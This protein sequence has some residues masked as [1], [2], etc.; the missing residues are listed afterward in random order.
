MG[1]RSFDKTSETF[2]AA[3]LESPGS[4]TTAWSY[5]FA[6]PPAGSY[7]VHVRAG[8]AAGNAT[9]EASQASA[10]FTI[11]STAPP[12]PSITSGP[13]AETASK[14]ASFSFSDSQP[15]VTFLCAKDDHTFATCS[16]P[17]TYDTISQGEHTFYV[18]ARDAAGNV[19][20]PASYTWT[21]VKGFAIEG[22]LSG[23]LAPG[24]SQP[25]HLTITNPNAK[26]MVVTSL[27]VSANSA[28]TKAGCD[29]PTNLQV[30]QSNVSESNVLKVAAKGGKVTLPSGTV[31]APQVLM[32]NLPSNQDA[33]K[34]AS[35]TLSYSGNGH[36]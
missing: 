13:E 6:L 11:K 7:T 30:T 29:A 16:S 5:A 20:A 22:N 4:S 35:F 1:R 26:A 23:E 32:K 2:H 8:D 34:G 24:V 25:L 18:E 27:Q 31:T 12:P 33:C 28:S 19:S 15:A 9:P 10:T 21:I 3:A 14:S 36:S 17:N